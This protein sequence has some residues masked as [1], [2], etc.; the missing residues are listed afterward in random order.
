MQAISGGAAQA[1][2]SM[3][4]A[5]AG[6]VPAVVALAVSVLGSVPA[7]VALAVSVLGGA[8]G[9]VPAVVAG[10]GP[11][12]EDDPAHASTTTSATPQARIQPPIIV[13]SALPPNQCPPSATMV[14]P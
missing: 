10:V 2:M 8:M 1:S 11:G 3:L 14:S 7:V 9:S 4:V 6:S 13:A 5:L 12:D